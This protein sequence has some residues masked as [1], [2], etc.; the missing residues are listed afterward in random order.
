MPWPV[1][2]VFLSSRVSS[3]SAGA[4]ARIST[5]APASSKNFGFCQVCMPFEFSNRCFE[6]I[7]FVTP[8][9]RRTD[10]EAKQTDR[11][12]CKW[13]RATNHVQKMS[14]CSPT[15]AATRAQTHVHKHMHTSMHTHTHRGTY[16]LTQHH[17]HTP[18]CTRQVRKFTT[19]IHFDVSCLCLLF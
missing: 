3:F 19:V 2:R 9:S 18:R 8:K 17:T 16:T 7:E 5:V 15:Q 14:L 12:M 6:C 1:R 11:Q 4:V 10:G 13:R